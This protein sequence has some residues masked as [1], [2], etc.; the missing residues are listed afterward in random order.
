[1][2]VEAR[3]YLK[4]DEGKVRCNVCP[5]RCV[6]TDGSTG[7]CG[8]RINRGGK[9]YTLIYGEVSAISID[10]I[11]KKPLFHFWPG[12]GTL[13]ISSVGCSFKCP[14]C[15]NWYISQARAGEYPTTYMP[16]RAIVSYAKRYEAP[17]ISYTYNEPIIWYEYLLDVAALAKKEGLMNVLVSNGYMTPE[18]AEEFSKYVDAANVDIKSW[19][20]EVYKKYCKAELEP[21]L[22][23]CKIMKE[24][25]V[26]VELTYLIIPSINDDLNDIESFC[27]WV[28]EELGE[29]TP[30]H[31]SKFYPHYK[32]TQLPPTPVELIEKAL[33]VARSAGL[34]YVYSGNVP[35]HDG[36]NT[37]CPSCGALV[38][39]RFGFEILEYNLTEDGMC[40]SCGYGPIVRGK[41][42]K[43]RRYFFL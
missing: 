40:K 26:H 36:E 31:F 3:N 39:K 22:E 17:S 12:S 15:Q 37:R 35:G 11:E 41:H 34:K 33:N 7:F 16:P 13:S 42:I 32:M 6:L 1:V 14:W 30:L 28:A 27:R 4:L 2:E 43:S 29:Y 10:P 19:R 20:E 9:L 8:T 23:A 25:G 21:V 38:I 5:H 18:T 24:K